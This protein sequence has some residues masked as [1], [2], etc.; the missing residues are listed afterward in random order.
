MFFCT[1]KYFVAIFA[2]V[3]KPIIKASE[4]LASDISLSFI[5]PV[6][7]WIILIATSSLLSLFNDA[8]IA[9]RDPWTSAFIII[10]RFL[11]LD[12]VKRFVGISRSSE[13][14]FK[15]IPE[16]YLPSAGA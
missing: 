8:L 7:I 9:S 3:L 11:V 1:A 14:P 16:K 10:F 2:L 5:P 12:K 13:K 6:A 15:V 4:A